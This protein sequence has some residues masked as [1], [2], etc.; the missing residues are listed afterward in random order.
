MEWVLTSLMWLFS[1]LALFIVLSIVAAM[2]W[3]IYM[4]SKLFKQDDPYTF[5]ID[6]DP[7]D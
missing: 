4:V 5:E 3:L 7:D 1:F 2:I 6:G